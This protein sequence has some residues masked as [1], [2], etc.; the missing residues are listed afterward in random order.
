MDDV[1]HFGLGEQDQIDSIEIV[2]PDGNRQVIV[3]PQVDQLLQIEYDKGSGLI[4]PNNSQ[5]IFEEVSVQLGLQFEHL[6][7]EESDLRTQ[8]TKIH[9]HAKLGPALAIGDINGD[10]LT[11][12]FLGGNVN[13]SAQLF[14]QNPNSTFSQ[15]PFP[16]DSSYQDIAAALFDLDSDGDLDLYLSSG[17]VGKTSKQPAFQDRLY[18]NDGTGTFE[19]HPIPL[20]PMTGL[21]AS[22]KP[23]DYDQD[24][25]IDLFLGGRIEPGKYPE[26]PRSYLLEN[27][28]GQL[29]DN[30]PLALQRIGMVTDVRWVLSDNSLYPDLLVI[31]EWMEPQLF[32]NDK[33]TLRTDAQ[34]IIEQA[35]GWWTHIQPLDYDQDGD[36]D[37]LLGNWGQN[38]KLQATPQ[39]PL[40][41][42]A[43]DFDE[44]GTIDPLLSCYIQGEEY[45]MHE[46]DLLITQIPGMKRRFPQ[47]NKYAQAGLPQ[48]LSQK[49]IGRATVLETQTMSSILLLNQAEAGYEVSALPEAFQI[50]PIMGSIPL[51]INGDGRLDLITAGNFQ[52]TETTQIG[53]YDSS[54]GQIAYQDQNGNLISQPTLALGL[55]LDGDIRALGTL[56]LA[57]GKLLI[58]GVRYGAKLVAYQ[59]IPPTNPL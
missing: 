23:A 18:L 56:S 28:N 25:D 45:I 8:R 14:F 26:T 15:G 19:V 11:D 48:T 7:N 49:D 39:Q 58:L 50:S 27:Q 34:P 40:R 29:V 47:Y 36:L 37:L 22:I 43:A 38:S 10:G 9:D 35:T 1:I 4:V 42:Y 33:G 24:G 12:V 44:N 59:F 46:R 13:Q 30:T 52:A 31:G 54:F 53:W 57:N 32:N 6:D 2:W 41:L 16:L 21:R 5:P 51:D 55:N 3:N 20:P 17:H